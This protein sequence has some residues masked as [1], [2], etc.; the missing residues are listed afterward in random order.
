V[1]YNFKKSAHQAIRARRE[2][3][4]QTMAEFAVMIA[5]STKDTGSNFSAR[6]AED[7]SSNHFTN[8]PA[9]LALLVPAGR[10]D[11]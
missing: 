4:S 10:V 1:C 11:G 5:M 2:I 6:R 7:F 8:P 3:I 9:A